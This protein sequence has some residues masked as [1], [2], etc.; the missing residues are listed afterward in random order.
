M[1][2]FLWV[3]MVGVLLTPAPAQAQLKA[4]PGD[5]PAWRGPDRTGLSTETGLLKEWPRDGPKLLWK[6]KGLGSGYSTPS[7]AGGRLYVM[8]TRG[9]TERVIALDLK[10]GSQLW[11]TDLGSLAGGH[12]GPRCTPTVDGDRVYALSSDGKLACLRTDGGA[13]VW[14]KELKADFGGQTGRWA[15]AESPLIDGDVLVCTPGGN[16]ATLVALDKKTG[17]TIWK[18]SVSGPAG[19]KRPYS[20]AGYSSVIVAEAGGVKQYVQFLGGGVVGISAKDGKF[21]WRYN[22]PAN[23]TANCSTPIF[24]DDAVFAA[25]AYGN[26]GGKARISKDGDQFTAKEEFFVKSM[27]NH[28]GGMILVGDHIYGTGS[29]SLLCVDFKTGKIVWQNRSVGKGSVAYA[30]GHLYV[31]SE[32]GPVALVEVTPTGYREKGRFEQPDRSNERSWAHP[33]IAGGLL[34][35]RDWDV[36]LCYDIKAR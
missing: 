13:I 14:K 1:R 23:G 11:A 29:G 30:D 18:A 17:A 4:V 5:W 27:Q 7:V 31:R 24:H 3:M 19:K 2:S 10:D 6:I 26:G 25:S 33:V 35:L 32:R 12:P 36:L 34:Y 16:T 21:L 28:H 8:G 9:R 22:A 20:T 15:Y